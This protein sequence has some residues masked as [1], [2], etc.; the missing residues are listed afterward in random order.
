MTG[1]NGVGAPHQSSQLNQPPP[2]VVSLMKKR[3]S[4][5]TKST[6]Q[7]ILKRVAETGLLHA[8]STRAKRSRTFKLG[9]CLGV[10]LLGLLSDKAS[11]RGL[12]W[13]THLL[14]PS[15]RRALDLPAP[16]SDS[17]LGRALKDFSHTQALR[18]LTVSVRAMHKR[19]ELVAAVPGFDHVAVD[20]KQVHW[21]SAKALRAMKQAPHPAVQRR[22]DSNEQLMGG[23]LRVLRATHVGANQATCILQSAIP[24]HTN[25]IGHLPTFLDELACAYGHSQL[26][27][28]LSLDAGLSSLATATQLKGQGWEYLVR[29]KDNQGQLLEEAKRTLVGQPLGVLRSQDKGQ[30]IEHRIWV[31]DLEGGGWLDWEHAGSFVRIERVCTR[32]DGSQ[33]QGERIWVSSLRGLSLEQWAGLCRGHWGC[34]NGQHNVVDKYL[35]E[36]QRLA[37]LSQDPE[38]LLVLSVLR[39]MALNILNVLRKVRVEGYNQIRSYNQARTQVMM[40][41]VKGFQGV[42]PAFA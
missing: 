21:L 8:R 28:V 18:A 32:S 20:G 33:T 39:A 31:H 5:L 6:L 10:A 41:L 14:H 2:I 24:A 4:N 42:I 16:A 30:K 35:G 40:E 26:I 13:M 12:E 3:K 11:Q 23:T 17:T 29:L 38:A 22:T 1:S 37:Q 7:A 19:G 27:K 34:E 15:T 36:D 9:S 25:E